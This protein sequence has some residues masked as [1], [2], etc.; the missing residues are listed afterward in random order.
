MATY[1]RANFKTLKS[2]D[3]FLEKTKLPVTQVFRK[4]HR[5][6][7]DSKITR[8][9]K[10]SGVN[11]LVS[12]ADMDDPKRQVRDSKKFFHKHGGEIRRLHRLSQGN[13]ELDFGIEFRQ[14]AVQNDSF[15][16]DLL[17][18]LGRLEV[19]LNVALYARKGR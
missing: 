11:I 7:P 14:A 5:R 6:Y 15:P 4:G 13:P 16:A 17:L 3:A 9:A 18:M 2:L 10:K 1:L 19:D 12:R 8:V